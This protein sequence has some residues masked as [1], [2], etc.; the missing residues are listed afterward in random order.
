MNEQKK[1]FSRLDDR[2]IARL[3]QSAKSE[4][5]AELSDE[6]DVERRRTAG[7]GVAT[8]ELRGDDEAE[9]EEANDDEEAA[10]RSLVEPELVE[11]AQLEAPDESDAGPCRMCISVRCAGRGGGRRSTPA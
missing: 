10:C 1:R 9:E 8:V 2:Q 6:S 3:T 11:L 7:G 4:L 5:S